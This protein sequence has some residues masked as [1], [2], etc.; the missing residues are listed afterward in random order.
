MKNIYRTLR[1]PLCILTLL[2]MAACGHSDSFRIKGTLADGASIN[3]RFLYYTNNAVRSALTASTDGKFELEGHSPAP[4][5]VDVYDNEYRLLGRFI[6]ENGD[7]ITITIDRKNPYNN[8]VKGNPLSDELTSFYNSYADTLSSAD[9]ATR[10][11]AVAAYASAYPDSPVALMLLATEFDASDRNDAILCDSLLR[12]L[13]SAAHVID[14]AVP[15]ASITAHIADT[16]ARQ[17]IHALTYK[18]KNN[19]TQTVSTS[20]SAYSAIA[21]RDSHHGRDSVLEAIRK[22]AK[23]R[24]KEKFALLD[25]NVDSDTLVWTRTTKNDSADWQQGWAA[26]AVSGLTLG[27]LGIPAVPYFILVDSTGRQLFRGTSSTEWIS[28]AVEAISKNK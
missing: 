8:K 17:P 26:G 18:A 28:T 13:S 23:H 7:D 27:H 5:A 10:N 9:I 4:T 16:A 12:S 2:I 11:R 14:L 19:R 3:L 24:K 22:L 20:R 15:F 25:L 6:A 21:I 1:L